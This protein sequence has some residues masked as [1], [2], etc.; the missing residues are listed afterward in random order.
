MSRICRYF[1]YFKFHNFLKVY[2]KWVCMLKK[3]RF[4]KFPQRAVVTKNDGI[5]EIDIDHQRL[6]EPVLQF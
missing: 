5:R 1:F 2:K 6:P 3:I 4:A